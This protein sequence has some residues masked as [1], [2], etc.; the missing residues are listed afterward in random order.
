VDVIAVL[1]VPNKKAEPVYDLTPQIRRADHGGE[2]RA[3]GGGARLERQRLALEREGAQGD[4]LT[5]AV[6]RGPIP[7]ALPVRTLELATTVERRAEAGRV[8]DLEKGCG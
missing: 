1:F 8:P 5:R 7:Q 3:A 4:R 2:V 6:G